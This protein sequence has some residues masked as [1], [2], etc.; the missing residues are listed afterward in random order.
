MFEQQG[1]S[2]NVR[3]RILMGK[4]LDKSK[5]HG[6]TNIPEPVYAGKIVTQE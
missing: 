4:S 6:P 1:P 3:R 2:S 5:M